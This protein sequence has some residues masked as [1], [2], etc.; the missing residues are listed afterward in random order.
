MQHF[1]DGHV[2]G[3]VPHTSMTDMSLVLVS[4][5]ED[6]SVLLKA[7]EPKGPMHGMGKSCGGE[8]NTFCTNGEISDVSLHESAM[9]VC[10][11]GEISDVSLHEWRN[12]RCQSTRME[13][14]AMSVCRRNQRCRSLALSPFLTGRMFVREPSWEYSA[15]LVLNW[16]NFSSRT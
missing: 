3:F 7:R 14:S 4:T 16:A 12:Q 9:S 5:W 6:R 2:T 10:T 8:K 13:K 15:N 11:N 1:H